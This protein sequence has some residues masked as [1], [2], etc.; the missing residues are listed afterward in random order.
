MHRSLKNSFSWAEIVMLAETDHF[1]LSTLDR[2]T[3]SPFDLNWSWERVMA[4]IAEWMSDD[5]LNNL[6]KRS[7]FSLCHA[8]DPDGFFLPTGLNR[9]TLTAM[10]VSSSV[11]GLIFS[12]DVSLVICVSPRSVFIALVFLVRQDELPFQPSWTLPH[13]T[14]IQPENDR[15][16]L[17]WIATPST[18]GVSQFSVFS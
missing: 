16:I 17:I 10:I 18:H 12:A 7:S 1:P 5:G 2:T 4:V 11:P 3:R 6:Y 9:R 15:A 8:N 13:L 14:R